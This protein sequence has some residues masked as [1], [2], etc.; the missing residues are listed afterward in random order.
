MSERITIDRFFEI[1]F[2]ED[3]SFKEQVKLIT[4]Q[5]E[6]KK[7]DIIIN[8]GEVCD[9]TFLLEKGAVMQ[10]YVEGDLEKATMFSFE[11]EIFTSWE[12]YELQ[13]PS[14][15]YI[16]CLEDCIVSCIR[17]E[18]FDSIR[19]EVAS[20]SYRIESEYNMKLFTTQYGLMSKRIAY[21]SE[22]FYEY[23]SSTDPNIIQRV[24]LKYIA[25]FMGISNEHLSR[26]R[27]KL[28]KK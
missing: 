16:Q 20:D 8:A 26:M 25:E 2:P 21:S 4:S 3:H 1:N 17:K 15:Y 13:T 24:P 28:M 14:E 11:G 22:R 27:R 9:R 7:Y 18:D 10:R 6:Y 12:S 5:I 23:I 19:D